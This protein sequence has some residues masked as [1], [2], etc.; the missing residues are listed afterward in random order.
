[1]ISYYTALRIVPCSNI[2]EYYA[3]AVI[4]FVSS[5]VADVSNFVT[6]SFV[7]NIPSECIAFL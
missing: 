6:S 5:L 1:M 3:L 4:S 7:N 2:V